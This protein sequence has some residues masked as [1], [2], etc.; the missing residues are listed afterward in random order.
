MTKKK[1][2]DPS[3]L[4]VEDGPVIYVK[5]NRPDKLN[6][7]NDDLRDRLLE[8]FTSMY[9]R[10]DIRVG[11]LSGDGRGV[12]SRTGFRHSSWDATHKDECRLH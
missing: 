7:L 2:A 11:V 3:L 6:A 10:H 9:W 8:F 5:M 4:I 1:D 12:C